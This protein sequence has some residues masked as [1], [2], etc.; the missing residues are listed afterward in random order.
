MELPH[1]HLML[2]HA[3]K[4][5]FITKFLIKFQKNEVWKN[6]FLEKQAFRKTIFSLEKEFFY[7][8][9][10]R[11][12]LVLIYDHNLV[13]PSP[14]TLFCIYPSKENLSEKLKTSK[15][16]KTVIFGLV[17]ST[18]RSTAGRAELLYRS[19]GRSTDMHKCACVHIG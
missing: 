7:Q 14:R 11:I 18:A 12:L 2:L 16:S 8:N 17:R 1:T 4:Q 6:R 9:I 19:T 5:N 13:F 3:F 15:F 10:V